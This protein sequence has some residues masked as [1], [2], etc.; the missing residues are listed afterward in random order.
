MLSVFLQIGGLWNLIDGITTAFAAA[1]ASDIID[2]ESIK[3]KFEFLC[4]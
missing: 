2:E 4:Q 1:A 3:G